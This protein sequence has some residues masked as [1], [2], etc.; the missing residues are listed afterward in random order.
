MAGILVT[1]REEDLQKL[2]ADTLRQIY[3]EV[4]H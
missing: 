2:D 4:T 3:H 1:A